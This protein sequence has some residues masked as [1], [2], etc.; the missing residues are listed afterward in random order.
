[1]AVYLQH[2]WL[3]ACFTVQFLGAQF[4]E[5]DVN[6]A[7]RCFSGSVIYKQKRT[8]TFFKLNDKLFVGAAMCQPL[9]DSE[10]TTKEQADYAS[11]KIQL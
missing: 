3:N 1:M 9:A 10:M 2:P 11:C 8:L 5:M 6:I 7:S 4:Q